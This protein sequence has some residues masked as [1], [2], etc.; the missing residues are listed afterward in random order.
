MRFLKILIT[1]RAVFLVL[2]CFLPLTHPGIWRQS[3]TL[4]VTLRYWLRFSHE[5]RPAYF[6][7]FFFP[8]V[9]QSGD[10]M[11]IQAMEFPILNFLF[12]PFFF[13]GPFWGQV[14]CISGITLLSVL[15]VRL[16][17]QKWSAV[18]GEHFK[19]ASFLWLILIASFSQGWWGKFIPDLI[20]VLLVLWGLGLL[21][22][23]AAEASLKRTA[24]QFWLGFG[25]ILI[26]VF[27]K[28]TS[29]VVLFL[30]GFFKREVWFKKQLLA[31]LAGVILS[32]GLYYGVVNAYLKQF[33]D[34]LHLFAVDA[35]NPVISLG[36]FLKEWLQIVHLL[37]FRVFFK[38]GFLPVLLGIFWV[39]QFSLGFFRV[40]AVQKLLIILGL[41]FLAIGALG[42]THVFIHDYYFIGLA[43]TAILIFGLFW[44][45]LELH[46][47]FLSRI[48][49]FG[50]ILGIVIPVIEQSGVEASK[51]SLLSPAHRYHDCAV[52]K[53]RNP[54]FPWNQ[55]SVFRSMPS[56]YPILGLCF[57][58]REGSASARFGFYL[59]GAFVPKG[60]REVDRQGEVILADCL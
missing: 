12:A 23:R 2:G 38:L 60:C 41:Q 31:P 16:C 8:A 34:G 46:R 37:N 11:G 44:Q 59:A 50:L 45:K 28:P 10:R 54:E 58:E 3:D 25:C 20:S 55:G 14:F 35:R 24:L 18:L 19:C 39:S 53:E 26:G 51:F 47:S 29:I 6:Q 9:L 21:I 30:I 56:L 1:A 7:E 33:H 13:F 15:L 22:E 17:V 32:T 48:F 40:Q 52:L 42:G 27:M 43:P 5:P 4:G 57:G 49:A 36:F